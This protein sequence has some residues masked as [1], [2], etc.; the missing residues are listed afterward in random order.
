MNISGFGSKMVEKM[1][2]LGFIKNAG[3]IYN[4]KSYEG[5]G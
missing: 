2:E 1:L 3:D 5:V 4:L